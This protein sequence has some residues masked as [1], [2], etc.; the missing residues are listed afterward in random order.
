M[1][2]AAITE[3]GVLAVALVS[4]D[5]ASQRGRL[6]MGYRPTENESGRLLPSKRDLCR[7]LRVPRLI[8]ERCRA[9]LGPPV[10][11]RHRERRVGG[12]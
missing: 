11:M 4:A 5:P 9:C 1:R 3:S 12:R 8:T 10:I 2:I 7:L 6:T